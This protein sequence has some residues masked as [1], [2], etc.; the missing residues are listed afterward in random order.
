MPHRMG[1]KGAGRGKVGAN[2]TGEALHS[3]FPEVWSPVLAQQGLISFAV[4][5]QAGG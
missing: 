3:I 4:T 1:P 5:E 2:G